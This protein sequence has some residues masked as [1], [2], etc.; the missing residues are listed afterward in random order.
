MFQLFSTP[1]W[2]NGWD[3]VFD[4]LTLII[5]LIIAG[6]SLRIYRFSKENKYAYFSLAFVLIAIA[7]LFKMVTQGLVYFVPLR[8]TAAAI[9]V[10]IVGGRPSNVNYSDLFFRAG[11]LMNML[12][13]LGA[14]LLLFFISQK[15]EGRLRKYYEVSQIGLY[16]YFVGLISFVANFKYTVFYLT[17]AVILGLTV[18]NYYKNY[19][20]ANRN[21]N[22]FKVML[23]F[24]FMLFAN[25]F[26][27]FVFI[28][29]NF[30]FVG[31][32]LLLLGFLGLMDTYR[33]TVKK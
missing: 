2:F 23:A 13:M 22:T 1:G 15:K 17:S 29:E 14:W 28:S 12:T 6:Y 25:I 8:D 26:F 27:V 21:V 3:I 24:M 30:Y 9:L 18:L 32:V 10:P 16:V 20:N 33:K 11:F 31:E 7:S 4:G 19:L 5:A